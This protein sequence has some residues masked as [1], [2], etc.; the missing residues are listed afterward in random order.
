M[1]WEVV[2]E[3]IEPEERAALVEAATQSVE[4][5][6]ESGWWRSGLDDLGGGP[7]SQQAWRGAGVV[8]P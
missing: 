3:P 1:N 6:D 7:A 2:P 8:E 4:G 5:E